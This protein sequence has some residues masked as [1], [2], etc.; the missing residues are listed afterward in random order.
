MHRRLRLLLPP[1]RYR[2]HHDLHLGTGRLKS[3]IANGA[4]SCR[5]YLDTLRIGIPM[6]E[7]GV[8]HR[9]IGTIIRREPIRRQTLAPPA[10]VLVRSHSI[11]RR[12]YCCRNGNLVSN[13]H[14]S[15][16]APGR[17]PFFS[18]FLAHGSWVF[19]VLLCPSDFLFP[20]KR[21]IRCRILH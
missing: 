21:C 5:Q 11:F 2:E 13:Y 20:R 19:G 3:L 7:G 17:L 4:L 16:V 10:D 14:H 18:N 1:R 9:T 6:R 12:K 15:A 8:S